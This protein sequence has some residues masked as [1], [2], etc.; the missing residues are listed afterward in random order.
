MRFVLILSL[1]AGALLAADKPEKG[2]IAL[3]N[4]KDLTGW[5]KAKENEDAFQVKDGSIVA[6]IVSGTHFLLHARH[7]TSRMNEK[8]ALLWL[9]GTCTYEHGLCTLLALSCL[10]PILLLLLLLILP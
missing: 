7:G 4:G 9:Y 1:A 2:F 6:N 5:T 8:G 10:P 3:F